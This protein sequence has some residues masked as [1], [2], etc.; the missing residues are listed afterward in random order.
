MGRSIF[1]SSNCRLCAGVSISANRAYCSLATAHRENPQTQ[2]ELTRQLLEL[3]DGST[4]S[5][6]KI[7][8]SEISHHFYRTLSASIS[9]SGRN[10]GN[11]KSYLQQMRF[12]TMIR[13][14]QC[15]RSRPGT[16]F[17]SVLYFRAHTENGDAFPKQIA[18]DLSPYF[19]HL[20]CIAW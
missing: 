6:V 11:K 2:Q 5:H 14:V 1:P 16:D 18:C 17:D 8:R 7:G 19:G 20:R 15:S 13:A 3:Y 9:V 12:F 10:F 4:T